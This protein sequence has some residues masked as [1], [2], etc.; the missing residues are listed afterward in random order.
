MIFLL[1]LLVILSLVIADE[2]GAP[3]EI[4]A[5]LLKA[6]GSD[7]ETE[8]TV[9]KFYT[10]IK[11]SYHDNLIEKFQDHLEQH[12]NGNLTND[13]GDDYHDDFFDDYFF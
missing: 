7:G 10:D 4:L 6:S 12:E 11:G 2:V 9:P 5:Q 1:T 3:S 13:D 8:N